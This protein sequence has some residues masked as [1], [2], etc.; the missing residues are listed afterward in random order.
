[1]DGVGCLLR[2]LRPPAVPPAAF[3]ITDVDALLLLAAGVAFVVVA[4]VDSAAAPTVSTM[5]V[6]A[7]SLA[8]AAAAAASRVDDGGRGSRPAAALADDSQP[9]VLPDEDADEDDVS[10]LVS[11]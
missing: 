6:N 2:F 8:P 10:L 4:S 3:V 1:M 7:R 5:G 9:L 11:C